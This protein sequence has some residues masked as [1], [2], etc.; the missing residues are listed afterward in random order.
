MP[1]NSRSSSVLVDYQLRLPTFEGPLDVLL[2][3]IEREQL[4][5]SD[6]SLVAVLDQFVA[7][8]ST[9]GAAPPQ[10]VAEFAAVAGRLSVLKSRALLPTPAVAGDAAE[11][12]DLV[13]QLEEYRALRLAADELGARQ[14]AGLGS[15]APGEGIIAP[16]PVPPRLAPL[17]PSALT[18]AVGRWLA[19][20]PQPATPVPLARLVTLREMVSRVFALLD[21]GQRLTFRH[22]RDTCTHRQEVIVA[23]LSVLSLM[24]RQAISAH[25]ESLFGTIRLE[26]RSPSEV[27][28]HFDQ[29]AGDEEEHAG[30]LQRTA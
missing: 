13:Q 1:V 28:V 25:Q 18:R 14:R 4:P 2:Q 27:A 12:V 10:V 29:F 21:G 19:R 30:K 22:I 26:R 17:P 7:F 11:E 8:A 24:R 16:R 5:I 23:F 3:L 9:L 6:I 15:F 20:L